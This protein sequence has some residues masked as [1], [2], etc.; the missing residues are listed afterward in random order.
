MAKRMLELLAGYFRQVVDE[1]IKNMEYNEA[2][3]NKYAHL[4]KEEAY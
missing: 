1:S 3:K 2:L 4:S